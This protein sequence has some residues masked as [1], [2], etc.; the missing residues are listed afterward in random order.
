MRATIGN[1]FQLFHAPETGELDF[2]WMREYGAT[3]RTRSYFSGSS[4]VKYP[5]AACLC[6]TVPTVVEKGVV[7]SVSLALLLTRTMQVIDHWRN[8]VVA[9]KPGGII[10]VNDW[11]PRSALDTIGEA[12]FEY[13][14]GATD[15]AENILAEDID[16]RLFLD[17]TNVFYRATWQFFSQWLPKLTKYTPGRVYAR[18]RHMKEEFAKIGKPLYNSS[19][20]EGLVAREKTD[21]MSVLSAHLFLK[22]NASEDEQ[23]RLGEEEVIAQMANLTRPEYQARVRAEIRAARAQTVAH[24][25]VDFALEDLNGMKVMLAAIKETLRF[26]P[27]AYHLWRV[28]AKDDI[29]PLSEPVIGKEGNVLNEIPIAAGQAV[30]ISIAGYNRLQSVW[31]ADADKWDPERFFRLDAD[32]QVKVGVYANLMSFCTEKHF[33]KLP[34]WRFATYQMQAVAAELLQNFEFAM[35]EDN[36]HIIRTPEEE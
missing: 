10:L 13:N 5:T 12:A 28:A 2:Q 26:H 22:A 29:I 18:F 23:P 27:I 33:T 32:K 20:K 30:T 6:P 35:P 34:E 21:I 9:D 8:M 1:E 4:G 15:D 25:D 17:A 11:L 14:F 7:H 19:A 31:G 36:P 16:A 3:W 24:G